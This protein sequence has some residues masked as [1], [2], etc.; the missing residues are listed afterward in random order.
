MCIGGKGLAGICRALSVNYKHFHGGLPDLL[1]LKARRRACG[2]DMWVNVD[3]DELVGGA[4][5]KS[6]GFEAREEGDW[7]D[8][9]AF[10]ATNKATKPGRKLKNDPVEDAEST[11]VSEPAEEDDHLVD[12]IVQ[13]GI[14]LEDGFE[15]SFQGKLV[16]VMQP[17]LTC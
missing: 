11:K 10:H 7:E 16:E 2:S 3:L 17:P 12:A 15:Y 6:R 1:L 13:D 5:V 8:L 9:R 14:F 4:G